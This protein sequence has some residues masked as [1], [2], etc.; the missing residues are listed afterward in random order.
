VVKGKTPFTKT[1]PERPFFG[2]NRIHKNYTKSRRMVI[3]TA[4]IL[5][6]KFQMPTEEI[7]GLDMKNHCKE[8]RLGG[9]PHLGQATAGQGRLFSEAFQLP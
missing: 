3:G 1:H 6:D 2:P 4:H 5:Q 7:E 9:G 8:K